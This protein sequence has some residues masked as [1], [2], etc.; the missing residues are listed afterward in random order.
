MYF[1]K[2][3]QRLRVNASWMFQQ[4]IHVFYGRGSFIPGLYLRMFLLP[5]CWYWPIEAE[6]CIY[7]SVNYIIIGSD[8]GLSPGR[9][10]AIIWTNAGILSN[11]PL[12]TNF[13]EI[14]IKIHTFSFKNMHL[15]MLSGKWQPFCL[16]LN[17][18]VWLPG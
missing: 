16:G 3:I 13:I 10:Q 2:W 15:K 17:V 8:N 18:S 11:G 5:V 9:G 4:T 12:G 6:W 14:L 7:A 1:L